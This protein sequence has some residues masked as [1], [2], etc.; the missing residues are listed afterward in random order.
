MK[1]ILR[2]QQGNEKVYSIIG[3]VL[4]ILAVFL[5]YSFGAPY[6]KNMSLNGYAQE[7]VNYDKLNQR[8]TQ[9]E[10]KS[11]YNKLIA[12]AKKK[13]LPIVDSHIKVDYNTQEYQVSIWYDYPVNL[14]V[15][16]YIWHFEVNKKTEEYY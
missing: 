13:N 6:F 14:I 12:F 11:I 8:P 7:L 16:K 1:N 10:A 5:I 9:N 2:N 4:L 15:Y 3:F